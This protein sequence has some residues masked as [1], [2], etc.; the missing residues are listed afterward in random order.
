MS[1]LGLHARELRLRLDA[2]A[3]VQHADETQS[4]PLVSLGKVR[5]IKS[6]SRLIIKGAD[7]HL[8]LEA[9]GSR[10]SRRH[11]RLDCL[12]GFAP[13]SGS[14][15]DQLIRAARP[16]EF[17]SALVDLDHLDRVSRVLVETGVFFEIHLKVVDP[18]LLKGHEHVCEFASVDLQH[19]DRKEME[20]AAITFLAHL[21][22]GLGSLIGRDVEDPD[23]EF[24]P[25]QHFR[26]EAGR[27]PNV[28][29][30]P[31]DRRETGLGSEMGFA[32][33][34][35][36]HG[37][38]IDGE[39]RLGPIR[40]EARQHLLLVTSPEHGHAEIVDVDHLG[41]AD[42]LAHK[43]GIGGE[44]SGQVSLA[45][46]AQPLNHA[47]DRGEIELPE[48]HRHRSED[49]VIAVLGAT[50]RL[51]QPLFVGDVGPCLD[52]LVRGGQNAFQPYGLDDA[53][54]RA[55][56]NVALPMPGCAKALLDQG[57]RLPSSL[58]QIMNRFSHRLRLAP[59][60]DLLRRRVPPRDASVAVAE[61][62]AV[63]NKVKN[64]GVHL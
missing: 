37:S 11:G 16:E 6:V 41:G 39:A 38:G 13:N 45:G 18:L 15:A 19:C 7:L 29:F 49:I 27:E 10:K 34:G 53:I 54:G 23:Q 60:V 50:E 9:R 17:D 30:A 33:H 48:R 59:A 35:G 62:D 36:D 2:V 26:R 3:D 42:Q 40:F 28:I 21:E 31:I 64:V 43:F 55:P 47:A 44:I 51:L 1:K 58:E 46:A 57:H 22:G 32:L 52:N 8:G 14:R 5:D 63:L 56:F 61:H 24:P 4:L 12:A 20:Q 25:R